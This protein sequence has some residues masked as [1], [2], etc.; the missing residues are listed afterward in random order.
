MLGGMS[1][2]STILTPQDKVDFSTWLREAFAA[3][4]AVDD[5]SEHAT[6][7]ESVDAIVEILEQDLPPTVF[8]LSKGWS[9]LPLYKRSADRRA[10]GRFHYFMQRYGGPA[11]TWVPGN[12][13]RDGQSPR[14]SAGSFGDYPYFFVAPDSASTIQRPAAMA[15]AFKASLEWHKARAERQR[16][17]FKGTATVGPWISQRAYDLVTRG[18]ARLANPNLEVVAH[19]A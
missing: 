8:V 10:G 17:R 13:I 9:S 18:S 5:G 14:I 6:I 12:Y 3:R 4:F 16:A 19:A 11:F 1:E 2:F 15:A 7:I